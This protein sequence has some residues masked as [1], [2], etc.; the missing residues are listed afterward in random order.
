MPDDSPIPNGQAS[1]DDGAP[2]RARPYRLFVGVM[3]P[4]LAAAG[5]DQQII[6]PLRQSV[7]DAAWVAADRLHLTLKFLGDHP[8][9]LV[10]PLAERL[11]QVAAAESTF[12][13]TLSGVGAFPG[14]HRP[15][16]IW[17]G[18]R[19][20]GECTRLAHRVDDVCA[21]F[22]IPRDERAFRPHVT[23]ARVRARAPNAAAE[24]A[25]REAAAPLRQE[26]T[27]VVDEIV[28]VRSVLTSAGR[29]YSVLARAPLVP[30]I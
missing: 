22:D 12:P 1:G 14:L 7:P 16:V 9:A 17:L 10:A 25:L 18:G 8:A 26:W 19:D 29:R 23:V 21:A 13:L 5:I 6:A 30:A 24:E 2:P 15:R 11:E 4:L 20:A 27:I 28:L 3:L